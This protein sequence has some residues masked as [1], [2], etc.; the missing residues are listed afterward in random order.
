M[1]ELSTVDILIEVGCE[2]I[3]H[4]FL[5]DALAELRARFVALLSTHGLMHGDLRVHGTARRLAIIIKDAQARQADRVE[6]IIGPP[7]EQAFKDGAPTKAAEGFAKKCG[8]DVSR[9][10]RKATD[11]TE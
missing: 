10:Q 5:P 9:L 11:K 4:R 3:P 7:V 2:E 1:S 6:E 8:V